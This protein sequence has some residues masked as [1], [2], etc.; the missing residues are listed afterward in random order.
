MGSAANADQSALEQADCSDGT[1][2]G[3]ASI[4]VE[5]RLQESTNV[6]IGHF[7]MSMTFTKLFS[8]ITESTVWCEPD[9][10]RIVW[11]A[12]LA[13]ADRSGR[14]WGSVPGL[15]NRARVPVEACRDAINCF[16]APDPDSRTKDHD[17]R[18]IA[19]IDGGWQLINHEKYRSMRDGESRREYKRNWIRERRRMSTK[20]S[21]VDNCR[22]Q[23]TQA[24]A[25]A[26]A[27]RKTKTKTRRAQ[28]A[29]QPLNIAQQAPQASPAARSQEFESFWAEWPSH[30]RKGAK[31]QC[32]AVWKRKGFDASAVRILDHVRAMKSSDGWIRGFIPAPLTYLNQARWDGAE[33]ASTP[34]GMTVL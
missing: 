32:L 22:P 11:I 23:Y 14:V 33:S 8:S 13:M 12:M 16:L 17:G 27:E 25:E 28:S 29:Q 26:E 19:E 2:S 10:T 24:E 15:A 1:R 18:R 3:L 6:Y 5:C 30:E 20:E 34:G 31:A 21:T 4:Y 9:Q 7:C